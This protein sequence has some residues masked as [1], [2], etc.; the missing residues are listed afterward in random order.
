MLDRLPTAV[1]HGDVTA[2]AAYIVTAAA[3]YI[4]TAAAAYIVLLL[5]MRKTRLRKA[6]AADF[7]SVKMML[8]QLP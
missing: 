5:Q 7:P 4:V 8:S 1:R 2:A 3:A 6:L